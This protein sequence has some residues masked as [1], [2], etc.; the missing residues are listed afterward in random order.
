VWR[1]LADLCLGD[2]V[3]AQPKRPTVGIA[4]PAVD[5]VVRAAPQRRNGQ[6]EAERRNWLEQKRIG[7]RGGDPSWTRAES[8]CGFGTAAVADSDREVFSRLPGTPIVGTACPANI[9]GSLL[10][11][12]CG[13]ADG[14]PPRS[15]GWTG[16]SR[17][18]V[19][20][21]VRCS[22]PAP[23]AEPNVSAFPQVSTFAVS[24]CA[25]PTERLRCLAGWVEGERRPLGM[26][27]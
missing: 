9:R 18:S 26:D 27:V 5:R 8:R 17:K 13:K 21:V 4:V 3:G 19:G 2:S 24:G 20:H 22:S 16:R 15:G 10:V 11:R 25:G 6:V 12:T 23:D 14:S 1:G 7:A